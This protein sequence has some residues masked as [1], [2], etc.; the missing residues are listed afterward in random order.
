M[1]IYIYTRP[2]NWT[3]GGQGLQNVG[4][5]SINWEAN[6]AQNVKKVTAGSNR[7]VS[8]DMEHGH[9]IADHVHP[10]MEAILSDGCGFFLLESLPSRRTKVAQQCLRST[11]MRSRRWQLLQV[12]QIPNQSGICGILGGPTVEMTV[13]K[14]PDENILVPETS[15]HFQGWGV[16]PRID[17]VSWVLS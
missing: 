5:V 17:G 16:G 4:L 15:A 12:S 14:R 8:E 2:Y 6:S 1:D 13:L 9:Y 11:S 10:L 3:T 7:K